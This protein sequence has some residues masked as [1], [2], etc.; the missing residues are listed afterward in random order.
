M[1]ADKVFNEIL[2][3]FNANKSTKHVEM[4]MRLGRMNGKNFD[5]NV[6][7]TVFQTILKA[8]KK[9]NK[10]EALEDSTT[11][12]YYKNNIRMIINEADDSRVVHTKKRLK[13]I[14]L[15][16]ADRPF[17]ARFSVSTETPI[18]NFDDSTE[19]D[20][21]KTRQRCS[22]TRKNLR[23]D[24]TVVTGGTVDPD[25]EDDTS[26]Q[27]E[28]EIIDTTKVKNDKELYNILYK[29]QNILDTLK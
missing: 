11:E 29:L 1:D 6:G 28:M 14:N 8:L 23:I 24:M 2:P 22:F 3:V 26:Y 16:L 10:W 19:M 5:T 4:E 25:C 20:D 15:K 7:L 21:V 18:E 13:N 27:V 17:D 12:I 9:Y